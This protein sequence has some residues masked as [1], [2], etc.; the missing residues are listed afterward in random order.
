[1][2]YIVFDWSIHTHAEYTLP[3]DTIIHKSI[4]TFVYQLWVYI[5]VKCLHDI[6]IFIDAYLWN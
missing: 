4:H 2:H 3:G 5:F 6:R 1:M